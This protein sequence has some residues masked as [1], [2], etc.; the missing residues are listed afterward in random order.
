VVGVDRG[1]V[2]SKAVWPF[3][4]ERLIVRDVDLLMPRPF[5][6]EVPNGLTV[7]VTPIDAN[8]CPG[9]CMSVP[10]SSC[11][12]FILGLFNSSP[13]LSRARVIIITSD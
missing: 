7:D 13:P 6:L 9:S 8:H 11:L 12:P 10:V 2:D 5:Q 1:H 4:L 3:E